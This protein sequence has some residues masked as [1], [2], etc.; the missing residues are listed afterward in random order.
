MAGIAAESEAAGR[1]RGRERQIERIDRAGCEPPWRCR[2]TRAEGDGGNRSDARLGC[3]AAPRG[4]TPRPRGP[5]R[6]P[7]RAAA[8]Q[9][10][11]PPVDR[12]ACTVRDSDAHATA[13]HALLGRC[14]GRLTFAPRIAASQ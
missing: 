5:P 3:A 7:H 2:C 9:P 4:R 13:A 14:D 1:V 12:A 10:C 11:V 8:P 6:E